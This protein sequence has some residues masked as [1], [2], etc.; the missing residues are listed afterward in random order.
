MITRRLIEKILFWL[1]ILLLTNPTLIARAASSSSEEAATTA[2]Q[3]HDDD[4]CKTYQ[5]VDYEYCHIEDLS[6]DEL[7]K[8]CTDGVANL[9]VED[10]VFPFLRQHY[11]M[12]GHTSDNDAADH[13]DYVLAAYECLLFEQKL[14]EEFLVPSYKTREMLLMEDATGGDNINNNNEQ[15]SSQNTR[16]LQQLWE[17]TMDEGL[18]AELVEEIERSHPKR[19]KKLL[20]QASLSKKDAPLLKDRHDLLIGVLR[21][22]LLEDPS[23]LMYYH[24]E[25][26]DEDNDAEEL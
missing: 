5:D 3:Q 13:Y 19:M 20:K 14:T 10:E 21:E 25:E 6:N 4:F 11:K 2:D 26:E 16:F 15:Q 17:Q 1:L 24:E 7:A 12:F 23:I 9:H 8:I 22:M 18:I